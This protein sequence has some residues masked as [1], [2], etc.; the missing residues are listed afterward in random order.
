[1]KSSVTI[2]LRK[3]AL[4]PA[5]SGPRSVERCAAAVKQRAHLWP[6]SSTAGRLRPCNKHRRG[7]SSFVG[8][9]TTRAALRGTDIETTVTASH[10]SGMVTDCW[11]LAAA[12][13]AQPCRQVILICTMHQQVRLRWHA[14]LV[15]RSVQAWLPAFDLRRRWRLP[16]SHCLGRA[17]G[18]CCWPLLQR[19]HRSAPPAAP[20]AAPPPRR[21]AG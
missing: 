8:A 17:P 7:S 1:L 5:A 19:Q 3:P 9:H 18:A 21:A 11:S 6:R 13:V 16:P 12:V 15:P 10:A 20:A 14:G 2:H 4:A